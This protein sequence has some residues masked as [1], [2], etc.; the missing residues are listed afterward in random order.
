[1]N[2]KKI[3]R[4]L[5]CL[6]LICAL[7]VNVSPIRAKAVLVESQ[8]LYWGIVGLVALA[9]CGVCFHIQNQYQLEA[10]GQSYYNQVYSSAA[11][12]LDDMEQISEIIGEAYTNRVIPF[13]NPN[14]SGGGVLFNILLVG[15]IA[16]LDLFLRDE[17]EKITYSDPEYKVLETG[18]T[19]LHYGLKSGTLSYYEY[20]IV[21]ASAPVIAFKVCDNGV[22]Y[23]FFGSSESFRLYDYGNKTSL[24][25]GGIYY[26][27]RSFRGSNFT[28][29][30]APD[31]CEGDWNFNEAIDL[32]KQ[33]IAEGVPELAL[34]DPQ[35][36]G[37]L[38]E[39]FDSV[40]DTHTLDIPDIDFSSLSSDQDIIDTVNKVI[41]GE[42][43]YEDLLNQFTGGAA[44]EI[45]PLPDTGEGS[46]PTTST[47]P[48]ATEVPDPG[49][50]PDPGGNPGVNPDPGTGTDPG[51]DSAETT[52]WQR[53]TQ[54]FQDL[55]TT[56]LEIPAQF[57]TY[58]ANVT[59]AIQELPSKFESWISDLKT[60]LAA[61]PSQIAQ[62][63]A[64]IKAAI[65]GIPSAILSGLQTVLETLFSPSADFMESKVTA[66][67]EKYP[68]V[69]TFSSLGLTFKSFFLNI[70]SKPPIIWIDLGAGSAW[71]PMGGK[72]KFL[73]LSWYSQFKPL[74]DNISGGFLWL[75]TGWRLFQSAPGIISGASGMF[76]QARTEHERSFRRKE[77]KE[78]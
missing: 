7:L 64:D 61:I 54:W 55:K 65:Q 37:G 21:E 40:G 29:E 38:R 58:F 72:V 45:V 69:D 73:D 3:L 28:Y 48:D 44:P 18:S 47:E 13:R 51:G 43:T 9:T 26:L 10:L 75:W 57:E 20:T 11:E 31:C 74:M 68:F 6:I 76:G 46:D 71:Y 78:G 27:E 22:H 8:L 12:N 33:L 66:L 30:N 23:S 17:P 59:T 24:S 63:A 77:S 41:S 62:T 5:I 49:V 60:G 70:G 39:N 56:I 32:C 35:F 2:Y 4:C 34:D 15:T 50:T 16:F 67:K 53:F 19:F 1:M 14:P 52:W 36:S 42:M 25:A